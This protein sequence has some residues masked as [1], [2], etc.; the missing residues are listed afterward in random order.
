[1]R[2]TGASPLARTTFFAVIVTVLGLGLSAGSDASAQSARP[3]ADDAARLC[4]DVQPGG[5]RLAKCL[6]EHE[7]ELSPACKQRIVEVKE[8]GREVPPGM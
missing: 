5:G 8:W 6:K 1:M 2:K 4:K 3:C 7:N